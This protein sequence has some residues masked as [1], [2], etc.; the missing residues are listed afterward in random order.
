MGSRYSLSCIFWWNDLKQSITTFSPLKENC[1]R[2]EEQDCV[3]PAIHFFATATGK[4]ATPQTIRAWSRHTNT[5]SA[6][7]GPALLRTLA[8]DNSERVD[9]PFG[10]RAASFPP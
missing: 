5:P 6:S 1:W 8:Q 9:S 3:I 7:I 10:G 4:N 2:R